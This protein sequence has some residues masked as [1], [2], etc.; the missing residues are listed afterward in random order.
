MLAVSK[1]VSLYGIDVNCIQVM[2]VCIVYMQYTC[3]YSCIYVIYVCMYVCR[4][5]FEVVMGISL[6][7]PTKLPRQ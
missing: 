1:Y 5:L 4:V 3:M 6:A 2:Y 7:S